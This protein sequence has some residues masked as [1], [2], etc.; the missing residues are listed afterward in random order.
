MY[1]VTENHYLNSQ[2]KIF[3][4]IK[5]HL[6]NKLSFTL[7][8]FLKDPWFEKHTSCSET[9]FLCHLYLM[10]ANATICK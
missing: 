6:H 4:K 10:K 3:P 2:E 5:Y 7:N 8:Y 9:G 1:V